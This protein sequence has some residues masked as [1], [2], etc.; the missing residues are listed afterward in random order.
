MPIAAQKASRDPF[1]LSAAN[2]ELGGEPVLADV[3]LRVPTGQSV[4][5]LGANGSGK[6]TLL[7]VMLGLQPL[8]TGSAKIFGTPVQK[9]RDWKRIGYVPQHLL[10]SSAVPV[11]VTEVVSASLARQGF[12]SRRADRQA[13]AGSLEAV[14]LWERRK[15]SFHDLSGGQQRRAMI[16]AALAKEPDVLLL[17]EPMAGLDKENVTGLASIVSNYRQQNRTV[18]VV[19]HELGTLEPLMDRCIIMGSGRGP[20]IRYDGPVKG[21]E[22]F[23]DRHS[24]HEPR[25]SSR[26]EFWGLPS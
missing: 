12:W 26:D 17:D 15:D 16:A 5:L 7:R 10:A 18:I 13:I 14:G 11:S 4:A 20:S 19:A 23:Q 1:L 22:T 2:V 21:A 8:T 6:S 3:E 9:Y 25:Q 24:H